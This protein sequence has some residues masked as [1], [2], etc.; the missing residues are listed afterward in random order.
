MREQKGVVQKDCVCVG[1][2]CMGGNIVHFKASKIL[3]VSFPDFDGKPRRAGVTL[4]VSPID[5]CLQV[6]FFYIKYIK[7]HFGQVLADGILNSAAFY[8]T[9][10]F[11]TVQ[12]CEICIFFIFIFSNF[13]HSSIKHIFV[14]FSYF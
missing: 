13:R 3:L 10:C 7:F 6:L 2:Q 11:V 5:N 4:E 9:W 12:K 14:M 8:I 1:W